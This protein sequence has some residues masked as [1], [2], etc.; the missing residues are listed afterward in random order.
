MGLFFKRFPQEKEIL[1]STTKSNT[2]LLAYLFIFTLFI[3]WVLNCKFTYGPTSKKHQSEQ[4]ENSLS[5]M[6]S[7]QLFPDK[8]KIFY[9]NEPRGVYQ[10]ASK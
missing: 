9:Q 4:Q 5:K 1:L 3:Y 8:F 7:V 10:P 2:E 6:G